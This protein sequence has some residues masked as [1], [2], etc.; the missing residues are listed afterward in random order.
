M[1]GK[2]VILLI[3]GL[4]LVAA[5]FA[6]WVRQQQ[7]RRA[8]QYWAVADSVVLRDAGQVEWLELERLT[9]PSQP[10]PPAAA[11]G[12][13]VVVQGVAYR[14]VQSRDV[15]QAPGLTHIRAAL[16]A[17]SS[18]AWPLRATQDLTANARLVALRFSHEV[19]PL[20]LAFDRTQC[21]LVP[22][23][24]PRPP[25]EYTPAKSLLEQWLS[26]QAPSASAA[27]AESP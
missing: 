17:D 2:W 15:S 26:E 23:D 4:G 20:T 7:G 14:V 1:R 18:F 12:S 11:A 25:L 27:P 22:C 19:Q 21:R 24:D 13:T 3:G 16:L 6:V 5:L 8:L 10:S 9:A